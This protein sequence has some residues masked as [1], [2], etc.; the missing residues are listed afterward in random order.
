MLKGFLPVCIGGQIFVSHLPL[1]TFSFVICIIGLA[2]FLG[3]LFPIYLKFRGGKGVATAFGFFLYLEPI[4]ILI[5]IVLFIIVVALW[6]YVSL[7]SLT[8]SAAMPLV[9][10]GLSFIKPVTLP[11]VLV[12][13]VIGLLIFIKHKSNIQRL[14]HATESQIETKRNL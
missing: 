1:F 6:R 7:G 14:F 3:H 12:S 8:A 11:N 9:L 5:V 2:A 4:A 13:V 10:V